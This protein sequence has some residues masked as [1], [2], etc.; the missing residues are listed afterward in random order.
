[1]L[2]IALDKWKTALLVL[3]NEK[4]EDN[5]PWS[6]TVWAVKSTL[7]AVKKVHLTS[8]QQLWVSLYIQDTNMTDEPVQTLRSHT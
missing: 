7:S 2:D 1:M 8:V 3:E 5:H 4:L 6:H